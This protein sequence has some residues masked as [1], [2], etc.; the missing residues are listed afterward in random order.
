M[1]LKKESTNKVKS[2]KVYRYIIVIPA[3]GTIVL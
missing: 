1:Q 3:Y 2:R